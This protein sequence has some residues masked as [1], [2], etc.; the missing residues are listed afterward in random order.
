M[1]AMAVELIQSGTVCSAAG[2]MSRLSVIMQ[3]NLINR[4]PVSTKALAHV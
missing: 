1:S 4:R 3:V 2:W